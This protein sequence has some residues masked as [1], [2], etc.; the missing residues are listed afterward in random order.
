[1]PT[2]FRTKA[3]EG[4][5]SLGKL[6]CLNIGIL[7]AAA[8]CCYLLC[9]RR[10]LILDQI[11]VLHNYLALGVLSVG[12]VIL[13]AAPIKVRA[14]SLI[15]FLCIWFTSGLSQL[16][17]SGGT[18]GIVVGGLI[19][20]SDGCNYLTEA[21]R[22]IEGRNMTAW[23]TRRPLG[24]TYLAGDLYAT[25]GNLTAALALAGIFSAI[26][27]G[28]SALEVRRTLGVFGAAL[29]L[30]LLVGYYRRYL[31]EFLSEHAGFA[32]G[33]LSAGLLLRAYSTG[34]LRWLLPGLFILSLGLAARAGALVLLPTLIFACVW[35]WRDRGAIFVLILSLI[36]V[37]AAFSFDYSFRKILGPPG[38]K[39][40]SNYHDVIYGIIFNGDWQKASADIPN[41]A[42]MDEDAQA[43]EV[44]KRVLSAVRAKPIILWRGA[45]RNWA[46]FF[47]GN[48]M[49]FGPFSFFRRP[50]TEN[51]L[52]FLSA[53]GL[54]W[55]LVLYDN[56]SPLILSVGVGI[57]F[58][59]PFIPPSDADLMRVYATTMPLMFLIPSFA[60]TGWRAWGCFAR[61]GPLPRNAFEPRTSNRCGAVEVCLFI[62]AAVFTIV[63][64]I[65]PMFARYI[66]P[67][68]PAVSLRST[69]T[70]QEL[71]I[72]LR[73]ASWIILAA[74]GD[75][76]LRESGH[77]SVDYF[78]NGI[79]PMFKDFYPKQA[80]FLQHIARPGII[81][82]SPASTNAALLAIDAV[83]LSAPGGLV[84]IQGY[85]HITDP[86]YSPD[87][88]EDR[89]LAVP[90]LK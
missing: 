30:W 43:A 6:L 40:I 48:K 23:G 1:M 37:I 65:L 41:Y 8:Y 69:A 77:F 10:L 62:T 42:R 67:I 87:F 16:Q 33:A 39:V 26:S 81:L 86:E 17:G 79:N 22:I 57:I 12:S 36:S 53:I 82:V 64:L 47:E 5:D 54:F 68:T 80:A 59:V 29:W 19:P 51:K 50:S 4:G 84:T 38:N 11:D 83:H 71:K 58:S 21:S 88:V 27:I 44:Y 49:A 46:A 73:R 55:S 34:A 45:A 60:F 76:K 25:H 75:S 20:Y 13:V 7:T 32:F 74:A 63:M 78:C 35:R 56:L 9:T 70:G 90:A 18:D 28:L 52:L 15:S 72:N 66:A 85:N 61:A 31:G 2:I 89:L 24:D 14:A 3:S